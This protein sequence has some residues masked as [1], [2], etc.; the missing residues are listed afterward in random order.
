MKFLH[1]IGIIAIT[2]CFGFVSLTKTKVKISPKSE[3][4]I[5]GKSNVNSFQCKYNSNYLEDEIVVTSIKNGDTKICLNN[6]KIAIKSK[7]F[8]CA[9]NMITRDFKT[10]LKADDYDN[11]NIELREIDIT[12]TN[13]NTRLDIEIAGKSKEYVIPMTYNQKT[14]N[15]K[16]TLKLNIKDF[17][18][19]SPKKLFGLIEVDET[20]EINFNLFL[21]Y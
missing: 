1:I 14:D 20:V 19:K 21:Q 3:V 2:I 17:D 8:D 16:G 7:G 10:I 5:C 12:N 4:I 6:A 18:L 9:N 13:L 11:I 15:A